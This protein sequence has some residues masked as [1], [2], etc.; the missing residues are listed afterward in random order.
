[1]VTVQNY[2]QYGLDVFDMSLLSLTTTTQR[3]EQ[4]VGQ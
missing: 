3:A 2:I 1:M 4:K